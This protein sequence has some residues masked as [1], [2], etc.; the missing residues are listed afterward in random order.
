MKEE[1]RKIVAESIARVRAE[2]QRIG[3][4]VRPNSWE[5][6]QAGFDVEAVIVNGLTGLFL[7][8]IYG[9]QDVL[10]F[11]ALVD[12]FEVRNGVPQGTVEFII[13]ME[14]AQS[15]ASCEE[16]A[17]CSPRVATLAGVTA[18]SGDVARGIGYQWTP[19]GLETLYLRSRVVLACRAAGL[20]HPLGGLWQ[21]IS[22]IDGLRRHA[23]FNR[24]LGYRGEILIHPSHV[25]PVN[26]IYTPSPEEIAYYRGMIEAFER[27]VAEGHAAIDYEGEHVDYAHVK[28]AK[29]W[30]EMVELL[31]GGSD[32]SG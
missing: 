24:Q 2:N 3:L 12:Y 27:A 31:G 18:K 26:E 32:P 10:R 17:R 4:Y 23:Q 5:S 28:T 6:G 20:N 19:E 7:P 22:D 9:P 30:L 29:E 25:A 15:I 1:A 11:E 8:K 13:T 16:I 14:T 21:N